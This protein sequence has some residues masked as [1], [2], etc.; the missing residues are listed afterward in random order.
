MLIQDNDLNRWLDRIVATVS[1]SP[2]IDKRDLKQDAAIVALQ[3]VSRYE[4]D[5][6]SG[7]SITT[8]AWPRVRGS[9]IDSLNRSVKREKRELPIADDFDAVSTADP[10]S[11]LEQQRAHEKAKGIVT[12]ALK[13]LGRTHRL[14]IL[15]YDIQEIPME[16]VA[17][18]LKLS[19]SHCY[20]KRFE[21][22]I[23]MRKWIEGRNGRT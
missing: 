7:A 12:D 23:A 14:I 9:C 4:G 8:Y 16:R 5:H 10:E 1:V 6:P 13:A 20:H 18:S 21:A 3:I 19:I 15:R 22:L 2:H 17:K 11:E